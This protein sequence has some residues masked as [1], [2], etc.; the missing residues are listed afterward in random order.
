MIVSET[1]AVLQ[2]SIGRGKVVVSEHGYD[3]LANDG[4]FAKEVV[5]G[6]TEA[7]VIEDLSDIL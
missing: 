3:Q 5:E 1:F 4:L 6:F 2:A 7:I